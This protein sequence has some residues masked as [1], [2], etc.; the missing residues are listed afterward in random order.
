[1]IGKNGW[2][3]CTP[4]ISPEAVPLQRDYCGSG[5]HASRAAAFRRKDESWCNLESCLNLLGDADLSGVVINSG[6]LDD[7][8]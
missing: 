2:I 1:M 8:H 6:L 4:T 3:S 7:G 5:S